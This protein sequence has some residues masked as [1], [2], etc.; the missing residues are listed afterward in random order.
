A[1]SS[2]SSSCLLH[3]S[4]PTGAHRQAGQHP[5]H[6]IPTRSK[7]I[8]AGSRTCGPVVAAGLAAGGRRRLGRTKPLLPWGPTTMLGQTLTSL[9]G[10]Q[11]DEALVVTGHDAAEVGKVAA[12]NGVRAVHN[13]AYATGEMISSVPAAIGALPENCAGVLVVLADQ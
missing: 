5:I 8:I 9:L 11:V 12:A 4:A 6:A 3:W 1:F 2:S 7:T 10:R 13:A